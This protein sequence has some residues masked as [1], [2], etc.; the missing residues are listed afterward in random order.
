MKLAAF[1]IIASNL[2]RTI[3]FY[4]MLGLEFSGPPG[5]DHLEA[6]TEAGLRVMLDSEQLIKQFVPGWV[7]Q[8]GNGTALAFDC[9]TPAEVDATYR[10]ILAAGHAVKT[11][12]WDAFWGQ[13]YACVLDP[14]GNQIDLFAALPAA[15]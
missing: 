15:P 8:V 5:V 1:G 6:K 14:D 12:P 3:A 4:R 10:A 2:S 11:E 9:G 13:R 7:R